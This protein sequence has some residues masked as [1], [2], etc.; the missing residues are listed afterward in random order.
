MV[1]RQGCSVGRSDLRKRLN[2]IDG[3]IME[4]LR[5]RVKKNQLP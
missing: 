3:F 1:G 4:V 5:T 2:G